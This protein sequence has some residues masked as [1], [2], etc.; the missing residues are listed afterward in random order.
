MRTTEQCSTVGASSRSS[1][2]IGLPKVSFIADQCGAEKR[3]ATDL[4]HAIASTSSKRLRIETNP[5]STHPLEDTDRSS[6]DSSDSNLSSGSTSASASTSATSITS[7]VSETNKAPFGPGDADD[8]PTWEGSKQ[9]EPIYLVRPTTHRL[10][11]QV[12]D[13]VCPGRQTRATHPTPSRP[14]SVGRAM[15]DRPLPQRRH[16]AE[17]AYHDSRPGAAPGH[18]L[19]DG[20]KG[21]R[22]LAR[23]HRRRQVR[24]RTRK[25]ESCVGM[26]GGVP[27]A[28]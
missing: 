24:E 27:S 7:V 12:T 22:G 16:A 19:G 21:A 9:D 20:A 18:Q 25:G 17:S 3:K 15:A 8:P 5:G 4:D 14:L 13:P 11:F 28:L 23:H 2:E 6:R 10:G 26:Y 1:A